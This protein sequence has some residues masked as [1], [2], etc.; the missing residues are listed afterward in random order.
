MRRALR[1]LVVVTV[2]GLAL[3]ACNAIVSFDPEAQ[4]CNPQAATEAE[5]CLQGYVCRDGKCIKDVASSQDAGP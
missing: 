5:K 3:S 4:P 1:P 2:L